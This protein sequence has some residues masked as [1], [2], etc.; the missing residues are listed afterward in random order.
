[1][2]VSAL[3]LLLLSAAALAGL[4]GCSNRVERFD[5]YPRT[6]SDYSRLGGPGQP[7]ARTSQ[8]RTAGAADADR[9]NGLARAITVGQGDSLD[10]IAR[11]HHLP[12]QALRDAN[13]LRDDRLVVGQT[14]L[15]PAH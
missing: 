5:S 4:T 15:I 13:Q 2:R 6:G 14:L 3:P 1:M 10:L 11:R 12:K 8:P 7:P 9:H